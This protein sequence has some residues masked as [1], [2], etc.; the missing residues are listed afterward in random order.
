MDFF[1]QITKADN[2]IT[3]QIPKINI[4]LFTDI[5]GIVNN[6]K[7]F[8]LSFGAN[9]C[10]SI[11]PIETKKAKEILFVKLKTNNPI[12]PITAPIEML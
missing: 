3:K 9:H 11:K 2:N 10:A 6:K 7:A 5:S 12:T 8:A 4:I 1:F